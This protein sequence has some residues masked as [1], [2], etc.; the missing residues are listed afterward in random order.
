MSTKSIP[1][2]NRRR[3]LAVAFAFAL[4]VVSL[5]VVGFPWLNPDPLGIS[6]LLFFIGLLLS[7]GRALWQGPSRWIVMLLGVALISFPFVVIAHGFGSVDIMAFLF[8]LEFGVEGA[9]ILEFHNEILI[10][11]LSLGLITMA[12]YALATL[13]QR[14]ILP[15]AVVSALLLA[16]HPLVLYAVSHAQASTRDSDLAQRLVAAPDWNGRTP[17]ADL[18][19]IYLE[20]L[21]AAY[22]NPDR[23]NDAL[24]PLA[25]LR[26]EALNL[27][28]IREVEATGWTVAGFVASQCGLPLLPKGFRTHNNYRGVDDFLGHHRCL[29]DVLSKAGYQLEFLKGGDT[30]F[31]GLGSFL[32]QHGFDKVIE[33]SYFRD[34]YPKNILQKAQIDWGVDDQ[35]LFAEA[36][37][38]QVALLQSDTPYGLFVQTVTTHG[39]I[40]HAS[41]ECMVDGQAGQ[42]RDV[43]GV[44]PC[45]GK[46]V[47]R[48]VDNLR[49]QQG[50]R[51]LKLVI[52]SDHLN[53]DDG[54]K[55]ELPLETRANT[56]WLIDPETQPRAIDREA[57]MMDVYPTLLD[58]LGLAPDDGGATRAGLGVSLFSQVP[59]VVEEKGFERLNDE[60]YANPELADAIWN[61]GATGGTVTDGS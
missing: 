27:T 7:G 23:F 9:G 48:F 18:V 3:W 54:L 12:T 53:H 8:H 19:V 37:K 55:A 6:G 35:L 45:F 16:L 11:T 40:V 24:A 13:L 44:L 47:Q 34:T 50:A 36:Q 52:M 31:A 4:L 2:Q 43:A 15:Y 49:A 57:S 46:Q 28:A 17:E 5:L 10:G 32:R 25:P 58:W 60:I 29:G 41:R 33:F 51:P 30:R 20:G 1:F 38:R 21:D 14:Q 59:T 22:F 56:V 39:E 61:Q 42:T 26:D